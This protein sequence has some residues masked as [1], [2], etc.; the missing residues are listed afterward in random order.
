M[1]NAKAKEKDNIKN[2]EKDLTDLLC[3]I[4]RDG[5]HY[6]TQH[7]YEKAYADAKDI[8]IKLIVK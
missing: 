8:V 5:G 7:G 2:A 1:T 6:I 4:H 3:I